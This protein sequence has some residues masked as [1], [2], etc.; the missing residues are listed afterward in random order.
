MTG[1]VY[2][3]WRD[4]SVRNNSHGRRKSMYYNMKFKRMT[5]MEEGT[6]RCATWYSETSRPQVSLKNLDG[7]GK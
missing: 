2:V 7:K 3:D 5:S 6:I 4:S 1:N